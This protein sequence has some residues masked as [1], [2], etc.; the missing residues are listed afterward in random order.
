[1]TSN[2]SLKASSTICL[3]PERV[4]ASDSS[5]RRS[6]EGANSQSEEPIRILSPRLEPDSR[7]L[8]PKPSTKIPNLEPELIFPAPESG[9]RTPTLE[10]YSRILIPENSPVKLD[11]PDIVP[12]HPEDEKEN[13]SRTLDD[14][15]LSSPSIS[16]KELSASLE[17]LKVAVAAMG[18]RGSGTISPFS[19]GS[20][21]DLIQPMPD[22]PVS[23]DP[24]A[25]LHDNLKFITS[26]IP[27]IGVSE[28]STDDPLN[29][30]QPLSDV[31]NATQ[32]IPAIDIATSVFPGKLATRP[33]APTFDGPASIPN[34]KKDF[35]HVPGD[36]STI[37][38]GDE[39]S[40][41]T[42]ALMK[43]KD[44]PKPVPGPSITNGKLPLSALENMP[45]TDG[46]W[47][48]QK[49]PGAAAMPPPPGNPSLPK[50]PLHGL[51]PIPCVPGV[52]ID[53]T[54][55]AP[56]PDTPRQNLSKR[57]KIKV[58]GQK[59]IRKG[60]RVVLRKSVLTVVLGRQLAGPTKNLLNVI[61]KGGSVAVGDATGAAPVPVP[62]PRPF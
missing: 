58:K 56:A 1:M 51:P 4:K 45:L 60:R 37:S 53:A 55:H 42:A 31:S 10:L 38:E 62:M 36:C 17:G 27:R 12:A 41:N 22:S 50:A 52:P 18:L 8:I 13:I 44:L 40:G 19:D 3:H 48:K 20:V 57:Q 6:P 35:S 54:G 23:E 32:I 43:V 5:F 47:L 49:L 33:D 16:A 11:T 26:K 15:L 29:S 2:P 46:C 21:N 34:I 7:K 30:V 25:R 9:S 14:Q 61:S 39:S 59:A 28:H 24:H